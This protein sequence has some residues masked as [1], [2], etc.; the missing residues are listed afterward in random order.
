M[1]AY[2]T[3]DRKICIPDLDTWS[4]RG[5]KKMNMNFHQIHTC[6]L[7]LSFRIEMASN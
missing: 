3:D 7:K 4:T 6:N 5:V 1:P 2:E